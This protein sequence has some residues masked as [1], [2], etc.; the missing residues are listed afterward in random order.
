MKTV[1]E[2]GMKRGR[3]VKARIAFLR[4]GSAMLMQVMERVKQTPAIVKAAPS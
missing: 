4:N 2:N 1:G 3:V